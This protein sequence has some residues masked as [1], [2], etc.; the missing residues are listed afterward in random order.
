MHLRD[1]GLGAPVAVGIA[2]QDRLV[3]VHQHV[4]HAPG[5]DGQAFDLRVQLHRF[6]DARLY[7]AF[8]GLNIPGEMPVL[9]R[10]AVGKAV[11]LPGLD[12][13]VFLPAHDMS[14]AGRANVN[15]KTIVHVIA[16][17]LFLF[18]S[19]FSSEQVVHVREMDCPHAL[20]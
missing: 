10:D 14:P 4:I 2:R 18:L 20:R 15:S 5:V 12:C 17:C 13:S 9:F 16:P 3:A 8:Q 7:M 1:D 6:V 11:D 19:L